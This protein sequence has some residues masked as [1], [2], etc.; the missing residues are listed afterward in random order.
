MYKN[1]GAKN[2]WKVKKIYHC[3]DLCDY[4][5]ICIL[6]IISLC[7]ALSRSYGY[8][9]QFQV[10]FILT[11]FGS[12]PFFNVLIFHINLYATLELAVRHTAIIVTQQYAA[13]FLRILSFF[14][15]VELQK[16]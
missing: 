15:H 14:L 10:E 2:T 8:L 5:H 12:N 4:I 13:L 1:S 11:K 16:A 3:E 6:L 7:Q 9:D